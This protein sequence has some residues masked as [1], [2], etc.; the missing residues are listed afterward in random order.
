MDKRNDG[1][2]FRITKAV[3]SYG[4][5][6][7]ARFLYRDDP[8]WFIGPASLDRFEGCAKYLRDVP[9][10]VAADQDFSTEITNRSDA[11]DDRCRPA[12]KRLG[13]AAPSKIVEQ[14]IKGIRTLLDRK[15][16]ILCETND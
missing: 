10:T 1:Q 7:D 4:L 13:K 11:R 2:T 16:Q 15:A 9:A 6:E 3:S 12:C 14:F 8:T 5:G